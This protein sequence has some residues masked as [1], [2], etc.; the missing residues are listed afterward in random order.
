MGALMVNRKR[1]RLFFVFLTMATS[2]AATGD[3]AIVFGPIEHISASQA[4]IIVL[5]HTFSITKNTAITNGAAAFTGADAGSERRAMRVGEAAFVVGVRSGLGNMSA[6]DIRI[7]STPYI[8]GASE[9]LVEGTISSYDVSLG[10]LR[11]DGS[12]VYLNSISNSHEYVLTK[13]AHVALVGSQAQPGGPIWVSAISNSAIFGLGSFATNGAHLLG[14]VESQT[15]AQSL[16][17]IQAI[18]GAASQ[19]ITGTGVQSITGTGTQS[20]T[21]TGRLSITGTGVQSITGT[22]VQSITGTGRLS[23]TGTG[24]QSITGTG[25]QSITGTGRHSITG[26]GR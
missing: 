7:S 26:T 14:A 6:I 25:I 24:V 17:D 22:G 2:L 12:S 5:G 18:A 9:V 3:N 21:G 20:I 1:V 4:E 8:P 11:I 13:G 19:S 10:V 23:I 16:S 15:I